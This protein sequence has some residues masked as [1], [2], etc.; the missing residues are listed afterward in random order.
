MSEHMSD[1]QSGSDTSFDGTGEGAD[2]TRFSE[3]HAQSREASEEDIRNRA[4]QIYLGRG[5]A[6]GDPAADWLEAERDVRGR[7]STSRTPDDLGS[8]GRDLDLDEQRH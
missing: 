3:R 6:D 8:I 4:Y 5:G 7:S 1:R 2:A